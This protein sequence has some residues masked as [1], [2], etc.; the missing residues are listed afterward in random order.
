MQVALEARRA[1]KQIFPESLPN[2]LALCDH[3]STQRLFRTSDLQD[4]TG[5]N[6][7]RLEP[8]RLW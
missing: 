5:L 6:F 8:R 3:L 1:P 2:E 7:P 4:A